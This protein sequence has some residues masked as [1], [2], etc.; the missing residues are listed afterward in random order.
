MFLQQQV[1]LISL[2]GTSVYKS[3]IS[4]HLNTDETGQPNIT[5]PHSNSNTMV[6]YIGI[7]HVWLARLVALD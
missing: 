4:R 6:C 7:G 2:F 5:S 1:Y 3:Q